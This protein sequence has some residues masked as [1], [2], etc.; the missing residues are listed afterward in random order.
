MNQWWAFK[1]ESLGQKSRFIKRATNRKQNT[2]QDDEGISSRTFG[3]W[4][5]SSQEIG[6]LDPLVVPN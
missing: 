3:I 1:N 2:W 6:I 5:I 4:P